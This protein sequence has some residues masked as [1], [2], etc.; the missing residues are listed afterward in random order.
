MQLDKINHILNKY[1]DV[2]E[3]LKDYDLTRELSFQRKR[4]DLTLSVAT[5]RKL[6]ELSI[7]TGKPVSR[8][9]EECFA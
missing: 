4:I 7:K 3:A 8:I 2:F 9:V 5:I 6:K 1:K